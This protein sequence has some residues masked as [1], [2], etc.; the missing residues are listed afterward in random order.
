MEILREFWKSILI[1]ASLLFLFGSYYFY[2]NFSNI[3]N[4]RISFLDVGQGDAIFIE[5]KDRKQILIDGGPN[6]EVLKGLAKNMAFFDRKID[7]VIATHP[8][9]DHITGLI[10]VL[11]KYNV[12]KILISNVSAKTGIFDS[13]NDEILR[14]D[15]SDIYI[16]NLGDEIILGD[17][18]TFKI[19]YPLSESVRGGDTNANSIVSLL[20]Y[21][22]HS[23]LL[24]GD[25]P[26]T[27]ENRIISYLPRNITL[28][29]AAHHGSNTSS[30][31]IFLNYLKPFYTI[32]S[33]GKDNR[34]GHPH[35]EVM[36]RLSKNS[37]SILNT[38]EDGTIT[39]VSNGRDL[40][41]ETEK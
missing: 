1:G 35:A 16:G 24:T 3:N 32:I 22:D 17:G 11:Q 34:Y 8:D 25:L 41:I 36:E 7:L 19:I 15:I 4:L 31:N 26:E 27:G 38:I 21:G 29:K 13:F 9:A 30:S 5:T 2:I 10:S 33:A 20:S 14:R 40:R 23:F 18:I 37:K 6:N 39:F 28:L 12:E